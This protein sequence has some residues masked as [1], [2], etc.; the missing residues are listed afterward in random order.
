MAQS[1]A[2][3]GVDLHRRNAAGFIVKNAM[4]PA[5]RFP[6]GALVTH[7]L[8]PAA[9]DRCFGLCAVRL[10]HRSHPACVCHYGD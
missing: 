3:R 5:S 2:V 9:K 7:P 10:L 4:I 8:K 6:H 1:R